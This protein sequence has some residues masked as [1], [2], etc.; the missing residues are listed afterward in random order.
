MIVLKSISSLEHNKRTFEGNNNCDRLGKEFKVET[1]SVPPDK[2]WH[3]TQSSDIVSAPLHIRGTNIR[4]PAVY[5]AS[6]NLFIALCVSLFA[7][8]WLGISGERKR[9]A[10]FAVQRRR[11]V[12]HFNQRS[13]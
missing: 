1:V 5:L 3:F 12:K 11:K 2:Y 7:L 9:I 4:K 13:S 10:Y 8:V 6:D